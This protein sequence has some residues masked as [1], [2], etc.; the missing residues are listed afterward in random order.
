MASPCDNV[1][2]TIT[3]N[4]L[5]AVPQSEQVDRLHPAGGVVFLYKVKMYVPGVLWID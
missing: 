5:D 1:S 2:N 3:V 4:W